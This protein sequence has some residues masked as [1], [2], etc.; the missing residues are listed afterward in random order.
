MTAEYP[1]GKLQTMTFSRMLR[2]N[3]RVKIGKVVRES[4]NEAMQEL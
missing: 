4:E 3:N 2:R 1:F